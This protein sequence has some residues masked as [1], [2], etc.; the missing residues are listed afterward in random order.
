MDSTDNTSLHSRAAHF[1]AG[2]IPDTVS[3]A[4]AAAN[5]GKV[6][7]GLSGGA[8]SVAL[9]MVL[10]EVLGAE[11]VIAVHCNFQLRGDESSRDEEFC[12]AL[13]AGRGIR[14]HVFQ[15]PVKKWIAEHGGSIEMGAREMRY[16]RFEE[17]RAA[18]DAD[19]VS[20]AHNAD[21]NAE[22][23]FLNLM[24][25]A[26]STGLK[27]MRTFANGI[28]RPLLSVT[29]SRIEEYL[30]ENGWSHITD[31]TNL[32]NIYRRNYIRHAILPA[33]EKEWPGARAAI[34][35]SME[36]LAEENELLTVVLD[37]LIGDDRTYLSR[38]AVSSCPAVTSLFRRFLSPFGVSGSLVRDIASVALAPY[39][40]RQWCLTDRHTLFEE[41]EGWRVAEASSS[42]SA[43][44][45]RDF[46][47]ETFNYTPELMERIRRAPLSELWIA[48]D[49]ATEW[50]TWQQGD[51]MKP[52]GM[53]G[54]RLVSDI[55]SDAHLSTVQKQ[56]LP[57]LALRGS[58]EI[59]W[60]P[61]IKRSRTALI[62]T[63][64]E[65]ILHITAA[66]E[67]MPQIVTKSK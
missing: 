54:S 47:S 36:I 11:N 56:T 40:G 16:E 10:A 19:A 60:I 59:I 67:T 63:D 41:R 26:G 27:G 2:S 15:C 45:S 62:T 9:T 51:R 23:F 65:L 3:R 66:G 42:D 22:T 46:H 18:E 13:C 53:R 35:S 29:R 17:V 6:V 57:L 34:Q 20:V 32:E 31:S 48:A 28:F 43:L 55:F 7:V 4:V 37:R 61:G 5:I 1:A 8:D 21:D 38:A 64:S 25:S 24:R 58:D 44:L 39:K 33:L 12:R 49:V 52:L 14:L 30:D 50:R